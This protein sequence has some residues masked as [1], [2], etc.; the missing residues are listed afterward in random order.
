M[1]KVSLFSINRKFCHS[2]VKNF[3]NSNLCSKEKISIMFPGQVKIKTNLYFM[4]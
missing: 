4:Y 3:N 2:N 1:R